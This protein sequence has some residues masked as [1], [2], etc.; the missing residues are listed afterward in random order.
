MTVD[1]TDPQW[2]VPLVA[3][4]LIPF[5]VAW[6]TKLQAS[7]FVK[8]AVALVCA[9]L[10]AV[11]T[12]LSDTSVVAWEALVSAF[13]LAVLTAAGSRTAITGTFDTRF[14]MAQEK[15]RR[16]KGKPDFGFGKAEPVYSPSQ[17]K[18]AA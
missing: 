14:A 10:T 5:A 8:S 16:L 12:Y 9:G 11:G 6:L 13:V 1:L 18:D 3:G 17:L 7:P 4:V 15:R 2:Y